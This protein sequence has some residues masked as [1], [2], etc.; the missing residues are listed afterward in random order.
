MTS[1]LPWL[2]GDQ[3]ASHGKMFDGL[4]EA[5][6]EAVVGVDPLGVIRF[7]NRQAESVFGY[8]RDDLIGSP[9]GLLVPG[10]LVQVQAAQ[11]EAREWA[12]SGPP[13]GTELELS[14]RRADGTEFPVDITFSPMDTGGDDL[15]VV[16]RS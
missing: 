3:M 8:R 7:V 15:L 16:G 12:P 5:L 13:M 14:G 6:P 11:V 1:C 10:S 4:L 9:F 2:K